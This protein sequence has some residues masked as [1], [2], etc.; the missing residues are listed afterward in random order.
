MAPKTAQK[1]AFFG[2]ILEPN[3][4][5]KPRFFLLKVSPKT[6]QKFLAVR[7]E[8]GYGH[9]CLASIFCLV[10]LLFFLP[11]LVCSNFFQQP[12]PHTYGR[13][14]PPRAA[15]SRRWRKTGIDYR[16]LLTPRSA[17]VKYNLRPGAPREKNAYAAERP[18][19]KLVM[20]RS[21]AG[22]KCLRPGAPHWGVL[23]E[24][25]VWRCLVT[26]YVA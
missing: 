20:P 5:Q 26:P 10:R 13:R 3:T 2:A 9:S 12:K 7:S 18:G 24:C 8:G 21:A 22:K 17:A 23:R 16:C 4:V 14:W 19:K 15:Q 25:L 1:A 6:S 11:F